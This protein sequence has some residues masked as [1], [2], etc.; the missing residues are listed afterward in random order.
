MGDAKAAR[1]VRD[2]MLAMLLGLTFDAS[3]TQC[4]TANY[5][6]PFTDVAGVSDAFCRGIME[7]Y[8]LGVTLGATA[9]TFAPNQDVPRLQMTTF[10]QRSIDQGLRRSNRRAALGQW[11]TPKT[12]T[13][14]QAVPLPG[15]GPA[16]LCKSDG[17]RIWVANGERAH[18]VQS[19][20]GQLMV[21]LNLN[22]GDPLAI[23]GVAVANGIVHMT[24][25]VWTFRG[26]TESPYYSLAYGDLTA[27][28]SP[29]AIA[30]DGGRLWMANY[31]AGTIAIVPLKADQLPDIPASVVVGGF[32]AP[33]DVLFDGT[34]VWVTDLDVLRRLNSNGTIAQSVPVGSDAGFMTFDGANLWVPTYDGVWVVRAGTG[35][36][37]ATI[38]PDATNRLNGSQSAAFDGERILVTNSGND[39]VTIFRAA[40]LSFIANIQLAAGSAPVG[41]CSDGVNFWV[42]LRGTKQLLRI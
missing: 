37:I 16:G 10:L 2:W 36:V 31:S 5:P 30:F 1:C 41:A 32:T 18:S 42:T 21:N 17:E 3:A 7:A 19:S 40:D 26:L 4:G 35:A 34:N 12:A 8:V 39:S 11:W 15:P 33:N 9:T 38:A 28:Y 23:F 29:G 6:F 25:P 27:S 22:I 20:N 13:G 24:Y 14:L